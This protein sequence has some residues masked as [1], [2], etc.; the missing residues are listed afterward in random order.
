MFIAALVPCIHQRLTC[1]IWLS[2]VYLSGCVL[3]VISLAMTIEVANSL[4]FLFLNKNF[5]GYYTVPWGQFE[6]HR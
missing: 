5:N 1:F 6:A 2:L 3:I 4:V